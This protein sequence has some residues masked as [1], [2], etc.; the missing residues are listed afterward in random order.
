M[1]EKTVRE[2][3]IDHKVYTLRIQLVF[4]AYT[5][6]AQLNRNLVRDKRIVYLC[7]ALI[8]VS[9]GGPREEKEYPKLAERLSLS[10]PE[11]LLLPV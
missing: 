4:T 3:I 2:I 11:V 5:K 6:I 1:R 8:A 10:C 9:K 7:E